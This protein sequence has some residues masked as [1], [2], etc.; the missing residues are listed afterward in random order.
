MYHLESVEGIP[1]IFDVLHVP[2]QVVWQ[3]GS[4]CSGRY[5]PWS[6]DIWSS[7]D[8]AIKNNWVFFQQGISN[9]LKQ[10]LALS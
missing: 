1:Y 5:S 8:A 6:C 10:I 4:L 3:Y 9:K 7:E 2:P